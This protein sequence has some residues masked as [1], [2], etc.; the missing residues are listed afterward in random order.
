MDVWK[1]A[2]KI[3]N[4]ALSV[5]VPG[6]GEIVNVVNEFLP[7]DK[8]ISE[9][10]T[11]TEIEAAIDTLPAEQRAQLM[12]KKFEVEIKEIEEWSNIM[13]TFAKA[14]A[15]GSSTRPWIA[16]VMTIIVG[17]EVLVFTSIIAYA[18]GKNNPDMIRAVGSAWPFIAFLVGIPAEVIRYYFG[19]RTKEKQ[20]RYST[21]TGIPMAS[22][23]IAGII[24]AIK[25]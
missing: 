9:S 12:L 22:N 13:S 10:S 16:K 23:V 2:R 15:S 21:A 5:A 8:H 20:A 17:F 6:Y 19:K 14:D 4:V 7:K 11:G 3:G 18:I 24:S 25:K 1:I